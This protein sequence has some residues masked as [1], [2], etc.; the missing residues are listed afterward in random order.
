MASRRSI[1]IRVVAPQQDAA[2]DRVRATQADF[3][4]TGELRKG[5]QAWT[6]RA[7]MIRTADREVQPVA[8]GCGRRQEFRSAAPAVAAR[9]GLG[10]PLAL[11]INALLDP[12]RA[13]PTD[14]SSTQGSAKVAIEQAIASIKQTTRERFAAAQTMLENALADDPDNVDLAVA[15]AA[16]QLRGI[17]MVWYSPADGPRPR[18][19]PRRCWSARCG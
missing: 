4:V 8:V 7:R 11:R 3:V 10:H 13:R 15:L 17:Q 2:A 19:K 18:K 6:L 5:E 1:I 14:G 12:A 16:L 9:R